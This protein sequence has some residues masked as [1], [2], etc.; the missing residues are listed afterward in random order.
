MIESSNM[1]N[2]NRASFKTFAQNDSTMPGKAAKVRMDK[3]ANRNP[4]KSLKQEHFKGDTKPLSF[5]RLETINIS[6]NHAANHI[7]KIDARMEKINKN[8]DRM[9]TGLNAIVKNYPPFP[10]GS[11][12]RT[13]RLKEI[14][15]FRQL[16]AKLTIPR[17]QNTELQATSKTDATVGKETGQLS[18]SL[19]D[20]TFIYT[21]KKSEPDTTSL[22]LPEINH[23]LPDDEIPEII[24][25]LDAESNIIEKQRKKLAEDASGLS[26]L[27]EK[28][29]LFVD[30][31][32]PAMDDDSADTKS[33]ETGRKLQRGSFAISTDNY[34]Q[35]SG[36]TG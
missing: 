34:S 13:R 30:M 23:D 16:I 7:K 36:F 15:G 6:L 21:V 22:N 20:N 32:F 29:G 24:K 27:K 18:I 4:E 10:P 26:R 28:S 25:G 5:G 8:I 19:K 9:K 31:E 35:I 14:D 2:L 11:E 33:M 12:E 1:A 3:T 17:E